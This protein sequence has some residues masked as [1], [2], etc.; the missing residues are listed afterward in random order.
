MEVMSFKVSAKSK[1]RLKGALKIAK[2]YE[3]VGRELDP[4]NMTW[5][6]IKRFLDQWKALMQRKT[7]DAALPPKLNKSV[8]VHK[9]LES[10]VLFLGKK[11]GVRDAPLSYIVRPVGTV[12]VISPPRQAGEPHSKMYESIEGDL[13]ARL[14]HAHA[15]LKVD[16]GTVF[17]L[18]EL[19]TRGSDVSPTIATF[20]KTQNGRGAMLRVRIF[21]IAW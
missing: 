1:M 8:P 3:N 17:D 11:V 21:G 12:A 4:E 5:D 14:S 6:V 19:S 9:W 16:N 13:T 20:C 15:L 2:F 18:I 10:M 7:E